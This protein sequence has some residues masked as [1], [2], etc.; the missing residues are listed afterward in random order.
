[1][2]S[3]SLKNPL[4]FSDEVEPGYVKHSSFLKSSV[5]WGLKIVMWVIFIA[6]VGVIFLYPGEIG[7]QLV[8]KIINATNGSVFGTSGSLFL[9]FS[10][11]ILLIAI[12]AVAHL[13]ISGEHVFEKSKSSKK[14]R[15]RLWT[16]PVLVD[17]PFGV[18]SAAEFIGITL[19][20]VFIIWAMY[21]YTLRN[22]SLLTL[23]DISSSETGRF[24][25]EL[26]GLRCGML[27][28]LCLIFLFLPVSRGSL[29]LRLID[30]PFEHATRYHV[31]LGH[32]TM[33]LFTLHGLFY[34]I[35]WAMNGT[36]VKELLE[37]KRVGIANLPGVIS[38][39]AGLFM[40]V[41]SLHPVRKDYFELFFYTH[42]LYVVFVVFLALHVGDFVFSIVAGAIFI[43]MLD[44]FLRFCQS[45]TKVDVL[46]AKCLPCGTVEL[47]LSKP[48]SLQ[49]NA[50][51][52]IFLQ[53][54]E[55]SWLQWHP[56]SVS[57]SPLDSKHHL[58]IL[59]KVLGGWTARLRDSILSMSEP[60]LSKTTITASVEGPYGHE[61]PYH[62]MYENL[63]LVAG[64]IG[65]SPFLA[66]LSDILHRVSDGKPCL[67]RKILVV[68]A[69]KKSDE[70]PLLSSID[71]ESICPFFSNKINLEIDIYV[72]R[73]SGPSMEEGKVH[74]ASSSSC[75][76]SGRS[77]SPLVGTGNN[78][79]SG[80]YV[81]I[82]TV[83]FIVLMAL[84]RIFYIKPYNVS[85]WWYLGLL[86]IACMVMSVVIFGG[87]VIGLWH[88]WDKK[89]SANDKDE[90]I[91][92]IKVESTPSYGPVED[93]DL[94]QNNP[95]SSTIIQYGTR[96][97]FKEIFASTSRKW[98]NVDV[99]VLVCGPPTLQSS[100]A[101][102][103][104]SHNI[105]RQ[106]HDTI[107]HFNSHS[108]DL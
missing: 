1:M 63:I 106:K 35:G 17:G 82:S 101:K 44:R 51:N 83:G 29:L 48:Q 56:F 64:G 9:V 90:D 8:E 40:W 102:E 79:W 16:F 62:L 58:A 60:E 84:L 92:R 38:L 59:I 108:F 33:M 50:L 99:G 19:F 28:L 27:G 76:F 11:P 97:D 43:F 37:W 66:I 23:F 68:W 77:M 6:W 5:K 74:V 105:R 22:I 94:T 15:F 69:V 78:V 54:R 36:L 52:F 95:E 100:V 46:S 41:T 42:Q 32:L 55:L 96:P 104:R 31:W 7:S 91:D 107:F 73:E 13:I 53:V 72:T 98:G 49:Y 87:L 86:F 18:V 14:P 3:N 24:M 88:L 89:A 2:G 34:V 67:P 21:A 25:L 85:T 10:A 57:S 93:K 80:L 26:T 103:I 65:I 45:R 20:V 75:P 47:V 81:I 39:L 30:I 4:L 12:L 71:M 70:L 61:T